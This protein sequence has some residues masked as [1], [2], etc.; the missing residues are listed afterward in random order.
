MESMVDAMLQ[1][2]SIMLSE[3]RAMLIQELGKKYGNYF[4]LLA[5]IASGSNTFPVLEEEMGENMG[6]LLSQLETDYELVKKKRPILTKEGTQAS[7][8]RYPNYSFVSDSDTLLSI[9]GI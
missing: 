7:D 3:G 1:P 6:G 9:K 8:T 5:A 2:D 4:S